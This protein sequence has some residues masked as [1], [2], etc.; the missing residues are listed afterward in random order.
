MIIKQL[1]LPNYIVWNSTGWNPAPSAPANVADL[2]EQGGK[3][4]QKN[5]NGCICKKCKELYPYS[6]PNESDGT[7]S[8]YGCRHGY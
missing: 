6:E 7:F 5:S 8:C 2:L 4:C 3:E 1:T